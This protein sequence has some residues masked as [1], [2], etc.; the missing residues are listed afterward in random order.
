MAVL[1]EQVA[2]PASDNT[3][4]DLEL[5][6]ATAVRPTFSQLLRMEIR[7]CDTPSCGDA[8]YTYYT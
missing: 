4:V 8:D 5:S 7:I 3:V 2:A 1:Q 6:S